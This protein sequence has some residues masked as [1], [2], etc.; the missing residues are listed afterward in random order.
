MIDPHDILSLKLAGCH[1]KWWVFNRNLRIFRD[2]PP[3]SGA[4]CS[5][6]GG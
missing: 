5:F 6:Q 1:S 4:N 2:L 3:F